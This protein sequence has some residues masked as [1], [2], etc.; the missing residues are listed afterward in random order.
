VNVYNEQTKQV[1]RHTLATA[2]GDY[3]VGSLHPGPYRVEVTA[4][5]F[6]KYLVRVEVR[7]NEVERRDVT[8]EVGS[9]SETIEVTAPQTMVNTEGPTTGQPIDN[10]TLTTLPLAEPDYLF[11]LGLS[12]GTGSE[13]ADVRKDGRSTVD[14]S[15]NGQRTTNNSVTMEGINIDDFNLGHFD[16]LPIPNP[17]AIGEFKVATSLYDASPRTVRQVLTSACLVGRHS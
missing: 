11:L 12:P 17:E 10:Q 3:S 1:E 16:Y 14:Y 7:L 5:G 8:L 2:A 4:K 15:V 9:T 13:P 6:K